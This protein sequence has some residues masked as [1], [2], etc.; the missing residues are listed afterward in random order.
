M[1]IAKLKISVGSALLFMTASAQALQPEV[2]YAF[3]LG[4]LATEND[5]G[6]SSPSNASLC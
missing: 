6:S 2:L 5:P 1:K 3:Q 4:P